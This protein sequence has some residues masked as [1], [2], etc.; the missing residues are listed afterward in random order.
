MTSKV[1]IKTSDAPS[2]IGPYSQAIKIGNTVY[3]SGQ[4]PVDPKS[5]KLIDGTI[6][7]KAQQVFKNLQA[8][9]NASGGTL[10]DIVKLT[11]FITDFGIFS[12]VN[13]VMATFFKE[14]FP[15]R[16]TVAVKALP[17]NVPLEV[18]GIMVVNQ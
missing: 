14:P 5:G 15:A 11:I 13:S 8:V 16:S 9:A 2:P 6:T 17:L 10:N 4:I 3:L 18:E 12:D 7:E 1:A